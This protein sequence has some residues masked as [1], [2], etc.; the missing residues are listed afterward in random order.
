LAG[1]KRHIFTHIRTY[2]AIGACLKVKA[3][4]RHCY[5]VHEEVIGVWVARRVRGR[6]SRGW[7]LAATG[8][9]IGTEDVR[10]SFDRGFQGLS[11]GG[12]LRSVTLVSVALYLNKEEKIYAAIQTCSNF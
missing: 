10:G 5:M 2:S 6:N 11:I 9:R 4:T 12:M 1:G 3:L 7:S 8:L